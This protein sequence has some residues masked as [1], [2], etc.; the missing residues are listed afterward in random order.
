MRKG[1][2]DRRRRV[3]PVLDRMSEP[4]ANAALVIIPKGP[5]RVVVETT[6]L[7]KTRASCRL[8]FTPPPPRTD[9]ARSA[10][11]AGEGRRGCG[12]L[13]IHTLFHVAPV[14]PPRPPHIRRLRAGEGGLT[15]GVSGSSESPN[16][17]GGTD[18][19][20][21][22]ES[23]FRYPGAIRDLCEFRSLTLSGSLSS[24]QLSA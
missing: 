20:G 1:G 6:N 2:E 17:A 21:L 22:G 16:F 9:V 18:C 24:L 13:A 23:P 4:A 8:G 3:D 14:P 15:V 19:L 7:Q 10:V 11:T 12:A 5:D